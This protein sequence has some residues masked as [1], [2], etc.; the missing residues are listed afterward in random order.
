MA[1][2]DE[3]EAPR[4][5]SVKGKRKPDRGL[6][7]VNTGDGKGKSTA[8]F[9]TALRAA[10]SGQ[11]VC[12]VQFMKGTW[13]YGE[14]EAFKKLG[15]EMAARGAGFTWESKDRA[16]DEASAR[17][18]WELAKEKISSG[19]YDLVVLD[20]INYVLGYGFLP[21]D[22]VVEFLRAR[23]AAKAK[24]HVVLTGGNAPEALVDVADTVTEMRKVKHAFDAGFLAV[25]G[26]EF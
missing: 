7:I 22:E 20:E 21:A 10:G 14:Q 23:I 5:Y 11:R 9:G 18:G 26:L 16:K 13:K 3:I 15:V 19:S 12:V 25:R 17:E 1:E 4:E 24:G 6:V 2:A 8:A